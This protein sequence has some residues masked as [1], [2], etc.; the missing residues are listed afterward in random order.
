MAISI[1]LMII[2]L[3]P[4]NGG[5]VLMTMKIINP[6]FGNTAFLVHLIPAGPLTPVG[7]IIKGNATPAARD[8]VPV[9]V[10]QERLLPVLQRTAAQTARL[11]AVKG[12]GQPVN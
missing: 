2:F 6:V 5:P 4:T 11:N 8:T 7:L 3:N 9:I 10:T 1:A 12:Y